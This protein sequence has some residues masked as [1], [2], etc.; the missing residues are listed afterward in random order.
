DEYFMEITKLV[1]TRSTCLRRQVGAIL[2]KEKRILATGYN[3]APTGLKHCYDRGGCLRQ[4]EK[5]PSGQRHELCRAIHAEMN[6]LLQASSYGVNIKG[7]TLYATNQPCILC[8]KMLINA[9]VKHVII[10]SGYPDPQA[11]AILKEAKIK[12][13]FL[14]N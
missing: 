2:V 12:I 11:V 14:K 10:S 1:A 7:S 8:A 13:K 4:K 6:V 3:G 9:G 5:I